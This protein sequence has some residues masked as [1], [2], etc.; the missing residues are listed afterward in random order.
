[1]G[2]NPKTQSF[3]LGFWGFRVFLYIFG[4]LGSGFL[5]FW[6]F[7]ILMFSLIF[8]FAIQWQNMQR[9]VTVVEE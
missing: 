7:D 8:C 3:P 2:K 1:M 4:F 5:G 6:V 9:R